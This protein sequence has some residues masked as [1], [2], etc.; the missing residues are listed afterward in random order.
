MIEPKIRQISGVEG[1]TAR[2]NVDMES[3]LPSEPTINVLAYDGAMEINEPL[4]HEGVLMDASDKRGCLLQVRFAEKHGLK[5]G[6]TLEVE[7]GDNTY[8]FVVRGLVYSPEQIGVS[9]SISGNSEDYGFMLVNAEAISPVPLQQVIVKLAEGASSDTIKQA[10]EQALPEAMVVDR[11]SHEST[12][13]AV[14]NGTLF[15][16]LTLLFPMLAYIVACMIV[17]TTLTRMINNQRIQIGTL[18]SLGYSSRRIKRHYLAYAF[19]PSLVGSLAGILVGHY[20]LAPV[21]WNILIGRSEYPYQVRP[22]VSLPAW[23]M[24]ALS[25][26][27]SVLICLHML[28]KNMNESTASLLRPKAP[29]ESKR[30]FFERFPRFWSGLSFNTKMVIRNFSRNK[31]R[32]LMSCVGILS[33]T[34]LLIASF[35]IQ[36]SVHSVTANHYTKTLRYTVRANLGQEAGE[37][38]AYRRRLSAESVQSILEKPVRVIAGEKSR[39]SL[40]TVVE[41]Q[42]DTLYLGEDETLVQILPGTL[43]IT[44]KLAE[45]LGVQAGDVVELHF[46]GDD[47]PVRLAIGQMVHN[48]LS[49]G[50]YLA[51]TT[52]EGL[53][54]GG[55]VP[56]A[57]QLYQPTEATMQQLSIMDEVDSLDWPED[58]ILEMEK[59]LETLTGIFSIISVVAL[60]LA[61]VICY[62]MGLMNFVER[63]REYATLKVLGY[64]QKEIRKLI[65]RENTI[66][67][68][69]GILVGVGAGIALT[70]AI[71]IAVQTESIYY[72]TVVRPISIAGACLVTFAF[73]YFIQLFLT[74]KVKDVDM[75]EAL[76]S[77][78]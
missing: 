71:L 66:V 68:I 58:Q 30:L 49:Q 15:A 5:A 4:L 20:L 70:G 77:V 61:F 72:P 31:L 78:E 37:A 76:K 38:A 33:C 60:A 52:W 73:S 62:N 51:R 48:N 21:V 6:D 22:F 13:G 7:Y 56:T 59:T 74:R 75:I 39:Q 3:T 41:D 9:L 43:V 27:S 50:L 44:Y 10:I 54:K 67:T 40:L 35:G 8:S 1:L 46:P 64:H 47:E 12:S 23:G 16:N 29:A 36:D 34:A 25:V 28:N 18:K 65:L 2:A 14:S 26:I 57:L 11:E 24:V 17:M 63:M 69:V 42:Q 55:F 32:T 45:T 19:F 53:R